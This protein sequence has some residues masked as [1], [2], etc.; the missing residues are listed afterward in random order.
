M[1]KLDYGIRQ[2]WLI[3]KYF[4]DSAVLGSILA[5]I[6]E[7]GLRYYVDAN[8]EPLL[9][10]RGDWMPYIEVSRMDKRLLVEGL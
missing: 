1:S 7:L 10:Y 8:G 2:P 6:S 4:N 5:K 3:N 9:H